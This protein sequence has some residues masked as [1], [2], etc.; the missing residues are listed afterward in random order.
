MS[1]KK[2][3]GK[4]EGKEEA[5][6]LFRDFSG[7]KLAICSGVCVLDTPSGKKACGAET[8]YLYAQKLRQEELVR[9]FNALKPYDKAGGFSIEG[10]GS[11]LYDDIRGS[12]FN[13]LGLPMGLLNKLFEKIG[14]N[15]LDFC[16]A[17][18]RGLHS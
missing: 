4:P 13:I 2:L 18:G 9:Y 7:K 1:G 3:I 10:I 6:K 11:I 16:K 17:R 5:K 12:Y 15:I 14:L 8:S